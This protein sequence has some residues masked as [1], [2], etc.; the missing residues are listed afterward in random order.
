MDPTI[1]AEARAVEEGHHAVLGHDS[2]GTYL[3]VVS[4]TTPGLW[5]RVSAEVAGG[6]QPV[7]W[8]CRPSA[9]GASHGHLANALGR[10]PC[11][12]MA[13][14]A[15]RLE[16]EGLIVLSLGALVG[17]GTSQWLATDQ[18]ALLAPRAEAERPRLH[19]VPD[20]PFAGFPVF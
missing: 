1:A 9:E 7:H 10:T 19:V 14:A 13:L 11:K 15:R 12:H 4:D 18:A 20:D 16:R 8:D 2:A 17:Q 5:Y 3:R 6:G